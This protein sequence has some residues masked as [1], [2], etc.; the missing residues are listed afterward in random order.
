MSDIE[1]L[2]D[3]LPPVEGE[4]KAEPKPE[5]KAETPEV[6]A[7]PQPEPKPQQAEAKEEPKP[8]PGHVPIAAILDERD[9]RKQAE[10][11]LRQ[12]EA[13][14]AEQ[15]RQRQQPPPDPRLNPQAYAD[16]MTAQTEASQWGAI[17]SISQVMAKRDHGAETLQQATDAFMQELQQRP[18]LAN[19]LRQQPHPYEWV[20][21]R[22]KREQALS[23]L[24]LSEIDQFKA[25]KAAQAQAQAQTG[26]PLQSMAAPPRSLAG[27]PSAGGSKPGDVLTTPDQVF[28]AVIK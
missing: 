20:V 9:R 11:R 3:D 28:A 10:E 26:Q 24:D 14:V 4:V 23:N 22:Y 1:S 25:W 18:W 5:P 16:Y 19:E 15:N 6:K 2:V 7:E 12:L 13:Q 27:L 21:E 8:E 17:T